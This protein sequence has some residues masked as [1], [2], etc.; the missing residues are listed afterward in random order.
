V[1]SAE[2]ELS[3]YDIMAAH[4]A[5]LTRLPNQPGEAPAQ[6][7]NGQSQDTEGNPSPP[8]WAITQAMA[9]AGNS[10]PQL[11]QIQDDL[12]SLFDQSQG[13]T[14]HEQTTPE[15]EENQS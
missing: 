15:E 14:S 13:N 8:Y 7:M 11:Q 1:A 5:R 4:P 6:S 12:E 2:I 3:I 9:E 10:D